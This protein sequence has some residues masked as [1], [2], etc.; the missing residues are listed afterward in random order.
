M[1]K[2]KWRD[3][4][5]YLLSTGVVALFMLPF[6]LNSI[7]SKQ[8]TITYIFYDDFTPSWEDG[9]INDGINIGLWDFESGDGS[10]YSQG[11]RGWGN[12]E[13]QCY[14]VEY[15]NVHVEANPERKGDGL[16]AI[17]ALYNPKSTDGSCNWTSARIT[18]KRK[19][20]FSWI[21]DKYDL[22]TI[23]MNIEARIKMPLNM[24]SWA[25][26]WL[27]PEP[28]KRNATCLG[29]GVYGGWCESGEI[30][31]VEHV[32]TANEITM[33][34]IYNDTVCYSDNDV[35]D[36]SVLGNVDDWHVYRIKWSSEYI[37]WYI[38]GYLVRTY[39]PAQSRTQNYPFNQPFYLI[40]NLAVGGY[41]PGYNITEQNH[42]MYIDWVKAYYL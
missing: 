27:L 13:L 19:R 4:I 9:F 37:K 21:R 8:K 12:N 34:A 16:L 28:P 20:S 2:S 7:T 17:S 11:Q 33:G 5:G 30:D 41:F 25:A 22:F 1:P 18:T 29:C 40:F 32:N 14:T 6:V 36:I 24:G 23:T 15:E 31:I 42:T 39:Y 26:F 3:P 35:Y 10:S 38:D